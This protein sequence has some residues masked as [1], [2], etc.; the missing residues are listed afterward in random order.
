MKDKFRNMSFTSASLTDPDSMKALAHPGRFKILNYLQVHGAATATECAQI[1]GASPSACSYHLRKLSKWGLIEEIP[2]DDGRERRWRA[3]V[4]E[5]SWENGTDSSDRK[6]AAAQL[7]RMVLKDAVSIVASYLS[8]GGGT[9]SR[10][11]SS[12]LLVTA[13]EL[14]EI[15]TNVLEI[16]RPYFVTNRPDAPSGARLVQFLAAAAP[17]T[18]D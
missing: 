14:D 10:V 6:A 12:G 8:G 9:W 11:Q 15:A 18:P 4:Q 3:Q 2:S 17:R 1:A 16:V 7:S 13:S 5:F